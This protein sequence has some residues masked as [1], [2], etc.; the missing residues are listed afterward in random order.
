MV[1]AVL[2]IR[3]RAQL[4]IVIL[5]ASL[6]LQIG[7]STNTF[8]L[9]GGDVVQQTQAWQILQ[10]IQYYP[11][12]NFKDTL[13]TGQR[14]SC[15]LIRETDTVVTDM[16]G[17]S[18]TDPLKADHSL[19]VGYTVSSG[20]GQWHAGS[21]PSGISNSFSVMGVQS[22]AD[23]AD[24]LGF[25]VD[26]ANYKSPGADTIKRNA[27]ALGQIL[28]KKMG[29]NW[30]SAPNYVRYQSLLNAWEGGEC[31]ASFRTDY[32]PDD[33]V[34]MPGQ[35]TDTVQENQQA[36]QNGATSGSGKGHYYVNTYK[37]G[38]VKL[39]T[40]YVDS[41]SFQSAHAGYGLSLDESSAGTMG[42]TNQV[43]K[44]GVVRWW[45][46][47]HPELAQDYMN[48]TKTQD[49][50]ADGSLTQQG[51][52]GGPSQASKCQ[53]DGIGWIIC[54]VVRFLGGIA[55]NAY[56]LVSQLLTVEPLKTDT[57]PSNGIYT[58]WSYMR[59]IA[60]IVFVIAFLV[61][62][63]SQISGAGVSNYGI[64]KL[65]PKLIVAAILVNTSYWICAIAVDLS[66]IIGTSV[67]SLMTSITN[68]MPKPAGDPAAS[69][70]NGS[71][72]NSG[73]IALILTGTVVVFL[74][75]SVLLPVLIAVIA[76]ILT[77]LVVLM[78]RQALIV[79]LIFMSPLAF[80]ALLLPN[81]EELFKR[82]KQ[83]FTTML[84]MFPIIALVFGGSALASRVINVGA[85]NGGASGWFMQII[86]AGV[87]V[88]PL[89]IVPTLMKAAGG[90]L[91]RFAGVV[92]N[93]SK[94]M[95]DRMRK[96]ADNVRE[97]QENR[98]A[99]RSLSG[100]PTLSFGKYQRSARRSAIDASLKAGRTR[101]EQQYI[102]DQVTDGD[103]EATRFGRKLAGGDALFGAG[104][105]PAAVSQAL[106]NAKFTIEKAELEEV[107]AESVLIENKQ[108]DGEKGLKAELAQTTSAAKRAAILE[109]MV[110]IGAPKDYVDEVNR[111]GHD[112]SPE[113]SIV[114][115]T[116]ARSLAE[117]GPQF[118]KAGD[119]DAIKT[120]NMKDDNGNNISFN[121][122]IVRNAAAGVYSQEKMVA[123]TGG[124][125]DYARSV[126]ESAGVAG[127]AGRDRMRE[128]AKQLLENE[129][130]KGKIKHNATAIQT[131][132]GAN[133]QIPGQ[134]T[135]F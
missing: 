2:S 132:A 30:G 83:L 134:G 87:A 79:I 58:A 133:E 94:G 90:L 64:K 122:I 81:T 50:K 62:I 113:N 121:D 130:L 25:T 31:K 48:Q 77:V 89:F 43:G 96:G 69:F 7:L 97:R 70:W 129:V 10:A 76:A 110:Q 109:R 24:K 28:A 125:L 101:S 78:L 107:K 45:L 124:N 44:S 41:D 112:T 5:L 65:L 11:N 4:L 54:P 71:D 23:F 17:N 74:G 127:N 99:L 18:S 20:D 53:I 84:L 3:S 55:D 37:D 104:A 91:N 33:N 116:L 6:A 27:Q 56:G 86:A 26:G 115:K 60:N 103:G 85:N 82:W 135:F 93:P 128:T 22:C 106:A 47:Q 21:P 117:N 105:N 67:T 80:V 98:R 14:G 108:M 12:D 38:S 35:T 13:T 75:L 57:S 16:F 72:G 88:I 32:I 126:L 118:L 68:G 59:N 66:N 114:R 63:Y 8:A 102:A 1:K 52:G 9:T 119:I 34:S 40:Y 95:F 123:D 36:Q 46:S 73:I 39:R 111:Y 19:S 120:G 100:K 61:I 49:P 15:D 42:C 92:N 29:V 131:I 51:G